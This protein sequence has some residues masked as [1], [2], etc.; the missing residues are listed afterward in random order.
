LSPSRQRVAGEFGAVLSC[1]GLEG[2]LARYFFHIFDDKAFLDHSGTELRD[3]VAARWEG[4]R[5]VGAMMAKGEIG[6]RTWTLFIVDSQNRV[7]DHMVFE[8]RAGPG[9]EP[10]EVQK[11][12]PP[13]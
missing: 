8:N 12:P 13:R 5:M 11:Q 7:V 1:A 9:G 2:R 10:L 6:Q 3:A 4:Q